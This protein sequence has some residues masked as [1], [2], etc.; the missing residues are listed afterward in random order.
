MLLLVTTDHEWVAHIASPDLGR[1]VQPRSMP[2]IA[3]TALAGI[4]WAA[5]NDCFQGLDPIA[6]THMLDRLRRLPGCR[7]VTVPDVV[8]DARATAHQ[9]ELWEPAVRRRGL[10]VCLVLQNGLEDMTRWLARTWHR[11][12]AV[13]VGG[14]D[15]WKMSDAAANIVREANARGLWTHMG[16]VNSARRIV[17]AQSI[18]CDSVDGTGWVKWRTANL[19]KGVAWVSAPPQLPLTAR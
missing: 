8:G 2:R 10:P 7:F 6:Y 17:Y 4:P 19:R 13:F 5:D 18:G 9:F 14:D 16:R 1:L 3:E 15:L 12:D 11:L